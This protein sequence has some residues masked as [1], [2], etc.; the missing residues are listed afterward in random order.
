MHLAGRRASGKANIDLHEVLHR[1]R[2]LRQ[3]WQAVAGNA[4]AAIRSINVQAVQQLF[5]PGFVAQRR[6]IAGDGAI[7][8]RNDKPGTLPNLLHLLHIFVAC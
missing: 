4:L 5:E 2:L 7:A 1:T 6:D 3:L 8:Q